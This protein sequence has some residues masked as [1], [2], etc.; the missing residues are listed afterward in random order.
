MTGSGARAWSTGSGTGA[1][2]PAAIT[3]L[4]ALVGA[5]LSW[6]ALNHPTLVVLAASGLAVLAGSAVLAIKRPGA[7]IVTVIVVFALI[8]MA[9]VFTTPAV[10]AVK[11]VMIFG[12]FGAVLLAKAL[13]LPS[14]RHAR[15]SDPTLVALASGLL[16][17]YLLDIGGHWGGGWLTQTR[18]VAEPFL[19]FFTGQAIG[20]RYGAR[21]AFLRALVWTSCGVAAYGLLQQIIGGAQLVAWGY[22]YEAQVRTVAGHLRS[23]GTLDSSFEYVTLLSL[24]LAVVLMGGRDRSRLRVGIAVLLALGLASGFVRT[25]LVIAVA[26]LALFFLLHD[27]PVVGV[28][29]LAAAL[30]TGV[31]F[32]GLA[33][34]ASM[35]RDAPTANGGLCRSTAGSASGR[36]PSKSRRTSSSGVASGSSAQAPNDRSSKPGSSGTVHLL[37]DLGCRVW[38]RGS[39]PRTSRLSPTWDCSASPRSSRSSCASQPSGGRPAIGPSSGP[40]S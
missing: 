19:L 13:R 30:V 35:S 1:G 28:S 29:L 6:L 2:A 5:A 8:P 32:L 40:S 15:P 34:Q 12:A 33:P 27:R 16:I 11:D 3:V 9:K 4:L 18:L 31:A 14:M 21:R 37:D 25:S 36:P 38:P 24:A 10:G 23:F 20:A 7:F 26:L 17:L 39:T 22:S